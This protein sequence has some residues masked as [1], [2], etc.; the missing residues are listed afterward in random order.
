METIKGNYFLVVFYLKLLYTIRISIIIP[1]AVLRFLDILGDPIAGLPN[2]IGLDE[3]IYW[4]ESRL[5]P[6]KNFI[7]PTIRGIIIHIM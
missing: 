2:I 6:Q 5:N 3:I 1:Q 4:Y 7:L